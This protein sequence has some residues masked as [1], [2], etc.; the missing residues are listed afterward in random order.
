M[1]MSLLLTTTPVIAGF[2]PWSFLLFGTVV[3]LIFGRRLPDSMR[4]LGQSVNEFKKGMNEDPDE[5]PKDKPGR[6]S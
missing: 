6:P 3:L 1:N 4:S 2:N 5:P